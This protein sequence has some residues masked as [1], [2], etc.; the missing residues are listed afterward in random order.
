MPYTD[1][2]DPRSRGAW[3][4]SAS[5]VTG[6]A[7]VASAVFLGVTSFT[8]YDPPEWARIAGVLVLLGS[9]VAAGVSG[10][11]G[12]G[13]RQRRAAVVGLSL[14]G[15]SAVACAVMLVVGG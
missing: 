3:L 1:S 10:A 6:I 14:A 11:L 5:V 9:L 2:L 12:L 7:A 4:G 15:A 13:G 8:A